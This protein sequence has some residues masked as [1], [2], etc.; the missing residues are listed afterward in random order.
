[1]D[2]SP[3]ILGRR[4]DSALLL[5]GLALS[6]VFAVAGRFG[7]AAA[8]GWLFLLF[9][10]G[11]N[12]PHYFQTY[13]L[14]YLDPGARAKHRG[15]LLA[16][17]ALSLGLPLA[18]LAAPSPLPLRALTTLTL[19]WGFWHIV[20]QS[21]GLTALYLRR[22][23]AGDRGRSWARAALTA[24]CLW[25]LLFR[26]AHGTLGYAAGGLSQAS[27][28]PR[29]PAPAAEAAAL[30]GAL[31]ALGYCGWILGRLRQRLPWSPLAAVMV[32]LTCV[33][34]YVGF[35]LIDDFV[36]SLVFL[37]AWHALQYLALVFSVQRRRE[38]RWTA[39][40]V[41]E[42]VVYFSLAVAFAFLATGA[43][44]TLPRPWGDAIYLPLLLAHYLN[45]GWL[46]RR[47]T[48][49]ELPRWL[50]SPARSP[51]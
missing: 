25:P 15:K 8:L 27:L 47:Q 48:N 39:L 33:Q 19:L 6:A 42:E 3:W 38:G 44:E 41:N 9:Q 11:F 14:T 30:L 20:Q 13:T 22:G 36:L 23:G 16:L 49:P 28:L 21:W 12:L 46:W 10:A 45:D 37:T 24:G 4:A 32:G 29:L 31:S 51:G 5:G 43:A 1:M 7:G 34:F 17:A 2:G 50:G 18:A 26:L 35:V 40:A